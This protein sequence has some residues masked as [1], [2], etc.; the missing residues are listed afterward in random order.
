MI[1]AITLWFGLALNLLLLLRARRL[2]WAEVSVIERANEALPD[3]NMFLWSAL[4]IAWALYRFAPTVKERLIPVH[5]V[6]A[7]LAVAL[8]EGRFACILV[9]AWDAAVLIPLILNRLPP[10][11]RHRL[12]PWAGFIL[13]AVTASVFSLHRHARFGSGGWDVGCFSH[14]TWLASAGEP[15]VSTVLHPEG[16][17]VLGD[18]FYPVVYLL[19]PVHWFGGGASALLIL[20]A[21][22]VAAVAFP[23]YRFVQRRI[24]HVGLQCALLFALLF[25]FAWQSATYFDF[26]AQTLALW[27]LA[28]ALERLDRQAYKPMLGW[29]AFAWICKE[30]MPLYVAFFGA[31]ILLFHSGARRLG[32]G[33][34]TAGL[35]G[36]ALT[37]G[38]IQPALLKGGP[39]G[40]IHKGTYAQFGATLPEALWEMISSP[41]RTLLTLM[42]PLAKRM[43][44]VTTFCG[45]GIFALYRPRYLVLAVPTVAERFLSSKEQM[46]EMGYHYAAPLTL[47]VAFAAVEGIDDLLKWSKGR[48]SVLERPQSVAVLVASLAV[49]TNLYGYKHP[50]NFL[51]WEHDYFQTV[52]EAEASHRMLAEVPATGAVEAMNHLLPHVAARKV[53]TFPRA[54]PKAEIHVFNFSQSAWHPQSNH[55]KRWIRDRL[56]RLHRE[57]RWRLAYSE[58]SA[59][60]YLDTKQF[61]GPEVKP[62]IQLEKLLGRGSTNRNL[63]RNPK[64]RRPIK[65]EKRGN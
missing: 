20:Q 5:W 43:S 55:S 28:E 9:L 15:L 56:R 27:P 44:F 3:A 35:A 32:T 12:I 65:G 42:S 11:P 60:L 30:N 63:Q 8:P 59:V 38:L 52:E 10:L 47:F 39:Q 57:K 31:F 54:W 25:S 62:S 21:L 17:H 7:L 40:M 13:S 51:T 6:S 19:A 53:A 18:H 2:D 58:A 24:D 36:F 46:W 33:I 34:F 1:Q 50:S 14:S 48:F 16:V 61:P 4:P 37:L 49:L 26:H 29:L 22:C 45:A 41:L 23:F 64:G